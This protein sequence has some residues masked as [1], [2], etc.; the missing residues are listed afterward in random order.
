MGSAPVRGRNE[1]WGSFP[2]PR[3]PCER[4]ASPRPNRSFGA[5]HTR[6]PAERRPERP[7]LFAP[8]HL[9]TVRCREC[10]DV[11]SVV[12]NSGCHPAA[13]RRPAAP[14]STVA[15][16]HR[17]RCFPSTEVASTRPPAHIRPGLAARTS[18]RA[19][20][21]QDGESRR[22]FP[23]RS[24]GSPSGL[25]ARPRFSASATGRAVPLE[26]LGSGGPRRTHGRR[27]DGAGG[28]GW[29][30]VVP[31]SFPLRA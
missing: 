17:L 10:A 14:I 13:G 8:G 26:A 2:P 30:R 1:L 25:P 28:R 6:P 31:G 15:R 27:T 29:L 21:G 24:L 11:T 22:K 12:G 3:C 19:S 9:G 23:V 16:I 20:A 4:G 5:S 18:A 7:F